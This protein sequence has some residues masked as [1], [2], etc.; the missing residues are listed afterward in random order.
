MAAVLASVPD[1]TAVPL[2][3]IGHGVSSDDGAAA[4]TVDWFR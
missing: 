4:E 2:S 3:E 1:K